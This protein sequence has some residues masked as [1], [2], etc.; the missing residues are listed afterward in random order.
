MGTVGGVAI[1]GSIARK[2]E[3]YGF[4]SSGV[5]SGKSPGAYYHWE[6]RLHITDDEGIGWSIDCQNPKTLLACLKRDGVPLEVAE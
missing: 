4:G 3:S 2:L 5:L 6:G 1:R